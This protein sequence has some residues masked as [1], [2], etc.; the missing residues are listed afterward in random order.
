[1]ASETKTLVDLVK[2]Q[3]GSEPELSFD[4]SDVERRL[5]CPAGR[6]T[7]TGPILAPV[8]AAVITVAFYAA[9]AFI[10]QPHFTSMFT[11]RGPVPYAIVFLSAWSA[12]ILLLKRLKLSLQRK[13]LFVNLLPTDDPGFVLTPSSAEQILEKLHRAVDDPQKFLLT[14]RIHNALSNLRNIGRIGDV[15][16]VLRTQA[17]NAENVVD[18]S[19]TVLRGFIWAIP[20][21]GFIGT[22]WGLSN[23]L[24]YFGGVLNHAEEMEQL[25]S[26]LQGVTGGLATAFETTLEGLIA[27]LA[28]H[29]LMIAVRRREEQFLDECNDYCQKYIISRLRLTS[30]EK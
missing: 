5:G 23:A 22:V 20:V 12:V 28:I 3:A 9:L 25:R 14:K 6:Y 21:L 18:S 29:M 11:Q 15:D 1:M 27:A 2:D 4:R 24:G 10:P 17:Q 26:A 13:A 30:G 7:N 19:Y 16:E 8:G